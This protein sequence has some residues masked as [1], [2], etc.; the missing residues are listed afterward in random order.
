MNGLFTD[1]SDGVPK[2]IK[3]LDCNVKNCSFN[4][5]ECYCTAKKVHVGPTSAVTGS[6][7]VCATFRPKQM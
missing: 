1:K 5:G 2:H 3:G 7:T 4:D 6:D